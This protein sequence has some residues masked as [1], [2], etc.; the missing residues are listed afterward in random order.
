MTVNQ[1]IAYTVARKVSYLVRSTSSVRTIQYGI[2]AEWTGKLASELH[3]LA[4]TYGGVEV[5]E[6]YQLSKFLRAFL[7]LE[8]QAAL[9]HSRTA[10]LHGYSR[11]SHLKCTKEFLADCT[12][13]YEQ[14]SRSQNN[15][16]STSKN[17]VSAATDS[18]NTKGVLSVYFWPRITIV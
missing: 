17:A 5:V 9:R 14:R 16:T 12:F 4:T 15:S 10:S 18:L 11:S 13:G 2:H 8:H 3:L 1:R 6:F 7:L